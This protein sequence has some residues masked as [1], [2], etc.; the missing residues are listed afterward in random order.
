[1]S[2]NTETKRSLLH[3]L[4]LY[5]IH[6]NTTVGY[7]QGII[8]MLVHLTTLYQHEFLGLL[9]ITSY[10]FLSAGMA[11]VAALLLMNDIPEEV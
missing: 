6:Y 8:C 4:T 1:M 11:Y 5:C 7:C 2:E 9:T 10:A 3:I